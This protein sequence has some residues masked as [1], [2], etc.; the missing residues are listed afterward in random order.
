MR[1]P[2]AVQWRWMESSLWCSHHSKVLLEAWFLYIIQS[3]QNIVHRKTHLKKNV[4]NS[5]LRLYKQKS[6]LSGISE[7]VQKKQNYLHG[8]SL[9][10]VYFWSSIFQCELDCAAP[11]CRTY[12]HNSF[13]VFTFS[14]YS[15]WSKIWTAVIEN[16]H[17]QTVGHTSE[18]HTCHVNPLALSLF[19]AHTPIQDHTTRHTHV[20]GVL[21]DLADP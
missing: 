16:M 11:V 14:F 15:N 18:I 3:H 17:I 13:V 4:K 1:C 12:L 10:T 2:A 21:S 8:Y 5:V 19:L 6:I 9:V 7:N 20:R